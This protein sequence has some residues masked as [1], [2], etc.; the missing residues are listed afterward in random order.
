MIPLLALTYRN[1]WKDSVEL[2]L[3]LQK[4][5]DN[6]EAVATVL[7]SSLIFEM[8]EDLLAI[9]NRFKAKDGVRKPDFLS[10]L[11]GEGVTI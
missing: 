10:F 5:S 8:H 11:N 6:G 4:R 2:M 3:S 1:G 9:Q 7:L